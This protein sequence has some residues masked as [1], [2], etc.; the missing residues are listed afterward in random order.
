MTQGKRYALQG[1]DRPEIGNKAWTNLGLV[2][3]TLRRS[4][5]EDL[6]TYLARVREYMDWLEREL[7]E[8]W[9]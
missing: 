7:R 4:G 1:Y 8:A 6:A 2:Q 5:K 3:E 9:G